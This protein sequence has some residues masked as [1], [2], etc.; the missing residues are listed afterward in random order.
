VT[1]EAICT[2]LVCVILKMM[3]RN[4][5]VAI[6]EIVGLRSPLMM[7][8]A[9]VPIVQSVTVTLSAIFVIAWCNQAANVRNLVSVIFVKK[10]VA[11]SVS[12]AVVASRIWMPL[13][14]MLI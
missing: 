3:I 1:E 8:V 7:V 4:V 10:M 5:A 6:V 12:A 14:L 9:A 13:I 11:T 2:A